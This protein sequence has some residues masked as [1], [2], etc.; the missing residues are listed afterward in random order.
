MISTATRSLLRSNGATSILRQQNVRLMSSVAPSD[1]NTT[2]AAAIGASTTTTTKRE[3][4]SDPP[5]LKSAPSLQYAAE[6]PT[7]TPE[8]KEETTSSSGMMDR[9]KITAEVTVSKIFPAGF[10]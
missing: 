5:Q 6:T 2:A 4:H 7:Y 9:F 8:E 3:I 10:G 1:K